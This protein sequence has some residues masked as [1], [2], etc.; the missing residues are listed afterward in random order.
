MLFVHL[1]RELRKQNVDCGTWIAGPLCELGA[2]YGF[3]PGAAVSA[4]SFASPE[5]DED[6]AK[7]CSAMCASN[8]SAV[9]CF[10]G[11]AR[12]Q[13]KT[14]SLTFFA[15][16][17]RHSGRPFWTAKVA[18]CSNARRLHHNVQCACW[19]R[20]SMEQGSAR[21]PSQRKHEV[22]KQILHI[23]YRWIRKIA[24]FGR[25]CVSELTRRS[26]LLQILV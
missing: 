10:R 20:V 23:T 3:R 22:G 12:D 13:S 24:N 25:H 9:S 8:C 2:V 11:W 21:S 17:G 6:L 16:Q 4:A 18:V 1:L 14:A 15:I 19:A 26:Y 5:K 7:Y